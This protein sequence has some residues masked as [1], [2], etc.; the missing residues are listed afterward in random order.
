MNVERLVPGGAGGGG[1]RFRYERMPARGP[2]DDGEGEEE[3]EEAAVPERRPEVLAA[4]ASF[5]L[6]EAAR[7]FEELP[8]ASI[9]AVSRP[10]AGDITPML[11]SY[12]IEV[13][14]KQFRWRLYKKAS[15][16]LYLHFALKRR[17]FLEEF[18]EKQEQVKEW[19]QN[20]G[21]GEHMPVGH[22]EDEADDV[23]VPAQAEENSI[24]HR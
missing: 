24:R 11:L 4:S 18:H 7:V 15:Q 12:T 22:D 8:R 13:H 19:L 5:R 23:N 3:E 16:V 1:G 20:L 17:E 2:A 21:I 6:S 10:D 14:Y 9:V